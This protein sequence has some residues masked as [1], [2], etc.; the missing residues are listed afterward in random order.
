ME[1]IFPITRASACQ[2]RIVGTIMRV[3]ILREPLLH[4]VAH[5]LRKKASKLL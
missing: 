4:I 1:M 3:P 2:A 5:Q